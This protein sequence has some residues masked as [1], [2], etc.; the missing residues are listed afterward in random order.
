MSDI[1]S[2]VDGAVAL[3]TLN[4]PQKYNALTAEMLDEL[5]GT[6]TELDGRPDVRAIVLLGSPKAFSAGADTGTLASASATTLWRSGFSEKWD[7]VASIETP[8]IAA[9]SGYALGGG[10]EL[11]LLCDIIIAD[12]NAVFGLPE[13]HIGIIPGAGGTQRLVRAVGKSLAM[14]MLLSG[15]RI[16][17]QEALRAGLVSRVTDALEEQALV[18]ATQVAK[19]AP[20]AAMMIKKAVAASYEMPLSAGVA[21]E[22]S[23][24]A[25][26]ADSED[27]AAGLAAFKNKQSPE[28]KGR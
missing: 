26:I 9:V 11:A 16:D 2:R 24:S 6:L 21:Y 12:S 1:L 27:R 8:L 17:A 14:D 25:L 18:L 4:R 28:F 10:L 20:L 3:V 13:S 23:L 15:R 22:R 5:L 19:A 7:R